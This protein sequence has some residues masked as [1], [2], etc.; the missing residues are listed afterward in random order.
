MNA[1]QLKPEELVNHLKPGPLLDLA[2]SRGEGSH[3]PPRFN[4]PK[5]EDLQP[6]FPE[7]EIGR[8]IGSGGMGCVFRATQ[9][10]LDRVIALKILPAE[11]SADDLF[12][13]RFAREARAMA[14]LHHPGIVGIHD[15][16]SVDNTHHLILEYLDGAS[17][18]ELQHAGPISFEET[19][20][21][22]EQIC[23]A[24]AY[25]HDEG[26]VHRDIKPENILFDQSG[27]VVLADFGLAR[28]A[29]DSAAPVSLTQTR[30]AMGTLNYMA[31][32][33]WENP[34]AV[35]HRADIYA[36]GILLY[37]MLTGRIPRGSFP[38]ASSLVEIPS[39]VDDVIHKSLQVDAE[40]RYQS[41][42]EF[43]DSLRDAVSGVVQTP[44]EFA[45]HGT[46]TNFR[47]LGA[48]FLQRIPRP[49]AA[50][51]PAAKPRGAHVRV[52]WSFFAICTL[53]L[54]F[55]WTNGNVWTSGNGPG[56]TLTTTD[57]LD[58][59]FDAP[60]SLM[61]VELLLVCLLCSFEQRIHPVRARGISIVL[62]G[63]CIAQAVYFTFENRHNSGINVCPFIFFLVVCVFAAELV[64]RT[65][66]QLEQHLRWHSLR[67]LRQFRPHHKRRRHN[68]RRSD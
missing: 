20:R 24:L 41:V 11:L 50:A 6:M 7:L 66:F 5:P 36:L 14:R 22:L 59:S 42:A 48:A 33:Q 68:D 65:L 61:F 51:S 58:L 46:V 60:N 62:L 16:G 12:A 63:F 64:I 43:A 44:L 15:F 21:I 8:L 67:F 13:E 38:P 1:E 39:A 32:E 2:S 27:R 18:R 30:Q 54:L 3:E 40:D 34:R 55:P 47:N 45:D 49:T 35:D 37:E 4:L 56:I 10:K 23:A 25:A 31:P 9:K 53:L 28:L 26:V 17:L 29:M 19:I 52:A 57:F